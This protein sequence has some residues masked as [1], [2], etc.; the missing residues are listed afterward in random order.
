MKIDDNT[1]IRIIREVA[2]E[3]DDKLANRLESFIR[4]NVASKKDLANLALEMH[5]RTDQK[6][7]VLISDHEHAMHKPYSLI[8]K[9][10]WG[11]G[12]KIA[13]ASSLG[14][15]LT[16]IAYIVIHFFS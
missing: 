8:P 3:E 15:I 16:A 1:Q 7:R 10:K 13:G 5:E 11:T 12:H 4:E 14:A 6:I 9:A 2:R